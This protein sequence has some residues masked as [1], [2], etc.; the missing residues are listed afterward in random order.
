MDEGP[1]MTPFTRRNLLIGLSALGMSACA[2]RRSEA[3]PAGSAEVN[4][5][6]SHYASVNDV[7]ESLV[8]RVVARESG[9]NPGAR[10]GRYYGLMQI[11]PE[12]ASTMGF[13][14]A[15]SDLLDADTNLRYGV[16]YL[17]GAW[18]VARRN[19][20]K[21]IHWYSSGYYYEAKRLGLLAATGLRT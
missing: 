21:A 13:R 20:D 3:R 10:N 4:R 18:I 6:I 1:E 7:P 19:P 5:L 12:T 17:R 9:Y 8:H 14:G 16:K 15:P 11:M 2:S